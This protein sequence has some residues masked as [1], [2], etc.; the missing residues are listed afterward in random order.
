[1][2]D[3]PNVGNEQRG[4]RRRCSTND[5]GTGGPSGLVDFIPTLIWASDCGD[6]RHDVPE[7][8][9]IQTP[10]TQDWTSP[11]NSTDIIA[12][13]PING[14]G[15]IS[16]QQRHVQSLTAIPSALHTEADILSTHYFSSVCIIN[17]GFDSPANPF[18]T[19]VAELMSI[20][21]TIYHCM[22]SMSAAHLYQ[23]ARVFKHVGLKYRTEA[24][25]CLRAKLSHSGGGSIP[26]IAS[27]SWLTTL[28]LGTLLLGM[29]SVSIWSRTHAL[30]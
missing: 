23:H 11:S 20:D 17:S 22:L 4:P 26:E 16:T 21:A 10:D 8:D 5:A 12:L 27:Q 28:L 18:R 3:D 13:R 14:S 6:I 25:R 7:L 1:M 15:S 24:I 19:Y 29:S 30:N 9:M 2:N